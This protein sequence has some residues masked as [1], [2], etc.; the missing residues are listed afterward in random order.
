MVAL[1]VVC[2]GALG[3]GALGIVPLVCIGAIGIAL[4]GCIG[5]V[6]AWLAVLD[7]A[8]S[9][10]KAEEDEAYV[11]FY[12]TVCGL[13]LVIE[14]LGGCYL[15]NKESVEP[16]DILF[17]FIVGVRSFDM[18]SDWAFYSISLR[19]VNHIVT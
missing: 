15:A 2:I 6:V 13:V 4:L 1:L 14:L 5:D 12:L 19:P 9:A 18:M 17:V 3:T 8:V 10:R 7:W 11:A 16:K